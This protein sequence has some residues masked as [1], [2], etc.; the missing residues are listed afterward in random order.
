MDTLGTLSYYPQKRE[1]VIVGDCFSQATI[2]NFNGDFAAVRNS[3]VRKA[4]VGLSIQPKM[5]AYFVIIKTHSFVQSTYAQ[6]VTDL[7][8]ELQ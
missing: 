2:K 8:T 3:D 1:S 5:T 4:R 6:L 7:R